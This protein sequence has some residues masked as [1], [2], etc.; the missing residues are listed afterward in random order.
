MRIGL[1]VKLALFGVA[2]TSAMACRQRPPPGPPPAPSAVRAICTSELGGDG[3]RIQVW[4]RMDGTIA[5][6]ELI[7]PPSIAD[8]PS[9][10]FDETGRESQRIASHPVAPGSPEALDA[11]RRRDMATADGKKAEVVRCGA[12]RDHG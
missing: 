11:D 5:T 1:G 3:A 2:A 10:F 12:R 4:R 8:A 9:V 7:A 6:L